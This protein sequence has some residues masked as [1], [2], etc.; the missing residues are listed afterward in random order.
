MRADAAFLLQLIR[1]LLAWINT[2]TIY[3]LSFIIYK[4]LGLTGTTKR[5]ESQQ[6]RSLDR[7]IPT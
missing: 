6:K 5:P 7:H 2:V 1:T 3:L 4:G